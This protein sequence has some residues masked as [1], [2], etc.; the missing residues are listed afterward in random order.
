V[1]GAH[2]LE[3]RATGAGGPLPPDPW[4]GKAPRLLPLALTGTGEDAW[5]TW[6]FMVL[7]QFLIE[8][9]QMK[10]PTYRYFYCF[11]PKT[12]NRFFN[13]LASNLY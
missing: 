10:R 7:Q 3:A 9:K 12:E 4:G 6:L 1:G 13:S 11:L 2:G 8:M 5:V